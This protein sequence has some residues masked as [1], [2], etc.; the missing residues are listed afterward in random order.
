MP[1]KNSPIK[2]ILGRKTKE[3]ARS[4]RKKS[5]KG[6]KYGRDLI[7]IQSRGIFESKHENREGRRRAETA[8]DRG[9]KPFFFQSRKEGRKKADGTIKSERKKHTTNKGGRRKRERKGRERLSG[10]HASGGQSKQTDY[11]ERQVKEQKWGSN[12]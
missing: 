10:G 3:S 11:K 4:N 12:K 8:R 7:C 9:L 6:R 1:K 5:E 2:K